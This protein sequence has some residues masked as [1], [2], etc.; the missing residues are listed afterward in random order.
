M[1]FTR[2]VESPSV[3]ADSLGVFPGRSLARSLLNNCFGKMIELRAGIPVDNS[4]VMMAREDSNHNPQLKIHEC[5][6]NDTSTACTTAHIAGNIHR[7]ASARLVVGPHHPL[8]PG[9]QRDLE[10]QSDQQRLEYRR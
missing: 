6:A 5:T 9:R 2:E 7:G 3:A 10:A 1:T 4:G 8:R